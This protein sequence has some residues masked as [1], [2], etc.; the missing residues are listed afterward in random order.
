MNHAQSAVGEGNAALAFHKGGFAVAAIPVGL[1]PVGRDTDYCFVIE[2]GNRDGRIVLRQ[3]GAARWV[4]V[5]WRFGGCFG[6]APHWGEQ[7]CEYK[8]GQQRCPM[9]PLYLR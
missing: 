1:H 8:S 9:W 5:R 7:Q 6:A 4:E 2:V 3:C